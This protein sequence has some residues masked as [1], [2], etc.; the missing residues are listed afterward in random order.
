MTQTLLVCRIIAGA[1]IFGVV[2]FGT[3][4]VVLRLGEPPGQNSF[5]SAIGAGFAFVTVIARQMFIGFLGGR[6]ASQVPGTTSAALASYQTRMI[7]GLAILEG[8]AFFNLI[9]YLIEGHWWSLAVVAAL[10]AWMIASYPTRT[11]L[12][13]WV[14]DREQLK[15]FGPDRIA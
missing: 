11:R 9:C 15:T 2:A 6:T 7:A 4:A 13:H 14:E 1:L 10:L 3:V 8:A 5:V 12:L